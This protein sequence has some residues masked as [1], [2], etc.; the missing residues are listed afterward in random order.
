M[1]TTFID[2][3]G[4][5]FGKL[6]VVQP[7]EDRGKNGAVRWVCRCD[8][9]SEKVYEIGNAK[10]SKSCGCMSEDLR[11][12]G[13]MKRLE[14]KYIPEPNSGC[15]L[16]LGGLSKENGYGTISVDGESRKAHRV[17]FEL[18]TSEKIPSG[19]EVCHHCDN[20]CCVNPDHLFVGTHI[21]N[22][23]DRDKKG[24]RKPPKGTFNGFSKLDD[25]K[26]RAIRLALVENKK[27]Q[28]QIADEFGCDQSTV[29]LIKLG[30][31]WTHVA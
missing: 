30:K 21:D 13:L 9:G 29:S 26:V 7:H 25:S 8:C 27:T 28:G 12:A 1:A 2:R 11:R 16:W 5:R 17:M 6:L 3:S 20:P 19:Y 22:M 18:S 14:D 4:L 23:R 31:R 10:R 24:R 15:W